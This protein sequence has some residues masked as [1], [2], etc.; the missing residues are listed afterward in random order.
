MH[1]AEAAERVA[2]ELHSG[3]LGRES[4]EYD[5]VGGELE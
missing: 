2:H 3:D 5:A 1:A 4:V